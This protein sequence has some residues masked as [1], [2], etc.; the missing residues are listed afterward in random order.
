MSFSTQYTSF[1]FVKTSMH[2][3]SI[4][5][6]TFVHSSHVQERKKKNRSKIYMDERSRVN[7][8]ETD[9]EK[10]QSKQVVKN[11]AHIIKASV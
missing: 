9:K 8:N 10:I 4:E 11:F 7:E 2:M 1:H 6:S 5:Y 3:M